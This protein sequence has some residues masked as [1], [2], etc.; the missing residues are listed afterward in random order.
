MQTQVAENDMDEEEEGQAAEDWQAAD[1]TV[2]WDDNREDKEEWLKQRFADMK[3]EMDD[4]LTHCE[5]DTYIEDIFVIEEDTQPIQV[6]EPVKKK[7]KRQGPTTR[8]H[9]Q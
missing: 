9:S 2:N 7:V 8:S 1:E 4:P 3:R 6:Q 5:G